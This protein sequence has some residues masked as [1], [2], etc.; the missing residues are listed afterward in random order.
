MANPPSIAN[1]PLFVSQDEVNEADGLNVFAYLRTAAG[2]FRLARLVKALDQAQNS[3]SILKLDPW[4]GR[5]LAGLAASFMRGDRKVLGWFTNRKPTGFKTTKDVDRLHEL[6]GKAVAEKYLNKRKK[7]K[8]RERPLAVY[9]GIEQDLAKIMDAMRQEGKATEEEAAFAKELA[10]E[11]PLLGD[12]LEGARRLL[13]QAIGDYESLVP[14]VTG[15]N[16]DVPTDVQDKAISK[17][18]F[19]RLRAE[20]LIEIGEREGLMDLPTREALA[21][22]LA[23]KY[24]GEHDKVARLVLRQEDGDPEYGLVTRLVPL[25]R[26]PDLDQAQADLAPLVGRYFETRTAQWFVFREVTRD[27]NQLVIRGRV[28]GYTVRPAEVGNTAKLNASPHKEDVTIRLRR[29][30]I[31]AETDARRPSDLNAV[32]AMLRR[33]DIAKPLNGVPSP[34]AIK[35]DPYSGW[36][37]RTLWMLEL[38]QRELFT[39]PFVVTNVLM[40]N[41]ERPSRG[42]QVPANQSTVQAVRL[43]GNRLQDHPEVCSLITRQRH[44]FEIQIQLRY[45]TNKKAGTSVILKARISWA[46]NHLVVMTGDLDGNLSV[47]VQRA[48][49]KAVRDAAGRDVD[50]D[51]LL[52]LL[53]RIERN[54]GQGE[55]DDLDPV[56]E[57]A[58][59]PGDSHGDGGGAKTG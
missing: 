47:E 3:L 1:H 19:L 55:S 7:P 10:V 50:V 32:R 22:A 16:E 42:E 41:F 2:R 34:T 58:D 38:M 15:G 49:V 17:A 53:R 57:T 20:D 33:A 35:Q 13:E 25:D 4:D 59:G 24:K 21:E 30:V 14:P 56:L 5:L 18:A 28:R 6:L 11:N 37:P 27:G 44:M 39:D 48:L 9:D 31:W 23:R 46:D 12:G 45:W 43:R 52:L 8:H 54:A 26:V 51:R 40:V 36:D 29:G